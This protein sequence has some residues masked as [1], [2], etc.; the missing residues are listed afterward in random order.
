MSSLSVTNFAAHSTARPVLWSPANIACLVDGTLK[1][2]GEAPAYD[3]K[4]IT[5]FC[6]DTR[7]LHVGEAFIALKAVRDG[8]D[9]ISQAYM[10]KASLIICEALPENFNAGFTHIVVKDSQQALQDIAQS[11][12]SRAQTRIAVTGSV[13]KT[14][15]KALCAYIFAQAGSCHTSQGSFNNHLGV[16][17]SLANLPENTQYGVFELGMN[18]AG[19]IA[20]LST[21]VKPHIGI[22]TK[23]AAAHLAQF[24]SMEDIARAKAEIFLGMSAD[25]EN[26]LPLTAILPADDA[27]FELLRALALRHGV[28]VHSFGQAQ[29]ANARILSIEHKAGRLFCELDVY[30]ICLALNL[31]M[32]GVHSVYNLTSALLAAHIAGIDITALASTLGALKLPPQRGLQ[33]ELSWGG[34]QIRL[35]DE[36]YNA[37]PESMRAAIALLGQAK[38][39]HAK[40]RQAIAVLGDMA[41]LGVDELDFHRALAEPLRLH[42]I[43]KVL[44]C[45]E[46]M[47]ALYDVLTPDMQAKWCPD[48]AACEMLLGQM[49]EDGDIVMIKGSNSVQLHVL[50]SRLIS[51]FSLLECADVL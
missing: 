13:G 2:G 27:Y 42:A 20:Q 14:S 48:S 51:Q 29:G 39:T 16:P 7:S 12:R 11:A 18:N 6:I 24:A 23:I 33:H 38:L 19:E 28:S 40:S 15:V 44:C 50:A 34:C 9:F 45:G 5:G 36:S 41:E 35:I 31:Q 1:G 43:D 10:Q 37:N 26:V 47:R 22:I 25:D 8:H 49:L 4:T 21:M 30:G 32:Q 17:L 3:V 46:K